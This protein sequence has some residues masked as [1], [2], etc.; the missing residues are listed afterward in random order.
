MSGAH[1]PKV[2]VT[3]RR[4]HLDEVVGSWLLRTFDPTFV[5]CSFYFVANTPTGGTVPPGDEF[6]PLG[7]G[8]GKYDEHGLKSGQS[9]TKLVYE[10]LFKRGLVPNDRFE[11]KALEW[12]VDFAHKEDTAQWE[13]SDP[14]S[15]TFAIPSILRGVWAFQKN[16]WAANKQKGQDPDN[17]MMRFGLQLIDGLVEQLNQRARFI[18]DWDK[19]IEFQSI[20]GKAV[21]LHSTFRGSDVE[22]YHRGFVLR[23][24]TDP[25]KPFGDFRGQPT[26]NVDLTPIYEQLNKNEP[27]AWYL[28]QSHKLLIASMDKETGPM[29][30]K[31]LEQLIDL[32]KK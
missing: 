15:S 29:T 10:D 22:A 26:S 13:V 25:T 20:W 3:H 9:A 21:A 6:V 19:R 24:Q 11:D 27:G 8:R 31:T 5:D 16:I 30:T 2:I 32:V 7:I 1:Q 4:P 23:I 17:V 14:H 18:T 28:H 12:L